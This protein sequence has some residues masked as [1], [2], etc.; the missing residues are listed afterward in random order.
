MRAVAST[1]DNSHARSSRSSFSSAS[2][3]VRNVCVIAI[4]VF[5]L[6]FYA[7]SARLHLMPIGQSKSKSAKI[8]IVAAIPRLFCMLSGSSIDRKNRVLRYIK[9]TDT[10]WPRHVFEF[11]VAAATLLVV[12]A[13]CARRRHVVFC[14]FALFLCDGD[15]AAHSGGGDKN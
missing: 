3:D 2:R 7:A 4:S 14:A 9:F 10:K 6:P 15:D 13:S 11:F 12:A 8:S 1:C 5:L